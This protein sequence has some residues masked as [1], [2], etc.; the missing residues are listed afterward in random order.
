MYYLSKLSGVFF[1]ISARD[2]D[3][4]LKVILQC[5]LSKN[6]LFSIT[7]ETDGATSLLFRPQDQTQFEEI[8]DTLDVIISPDRYYCYQLDTENPALNETGMLSKVTTFLAEH[9]IPILCLSTFNC[10]YVYY[11]IQY[12]DKMIE[13]IKSDPENYSLDEEELTI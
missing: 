9:Q 8:I 2:Q 12:A 3:K 10:N 4:I 6:S 11:P 7:R 13:A 1:L 5:I